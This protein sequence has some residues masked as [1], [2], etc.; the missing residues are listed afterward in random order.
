MNTE[1]KK[2]YFALSA[3]ALLLVSACSTDFVSPR[4][5]SSEPL[6]EYFNTEARIFESLVAAYDPLE[7]FDYAFGQYD[8]LHLVNDIM[9]D[10]MYCGG[11]NDGDQPILVKTHYYSLTPTEQPNQI[12]TVCYS[13]INRANTLLQ[14]VDG[15]AALSDANKV[16]YRAEATVL[17]NLYYTLL[18]KYWGNIP[19]YEENLKAPYIGTQ[20]GHDEVYANI[21]KSLE[22]VIALNVLPMKAAVGNEGRVTQAMAYMLYAEVVM[23]QKDNSRYQT[24]LNYMKEIITSSKYSLVSDFASIWLE[25]GEWGSESIWEINYISEGG[26]RSWGNSIA[27]GGEVYSV[28][29]GIPAEKGTEFQEGWGFGTIAKSAYDMYDNTDI[30]RD[31]GILNFEAYATAH[32]GATYTPRWQDTGYFNL[33]YLPYKGGNHGYLA[34]DNLNYGNNF[35]YYR[36][37]ETL[38]NAAE[39]SNLLGQDGTS[40]LTEVRNRAKSQDTGTSYDDIIQER[41]KEFVGEGKRYWDL[42][43]SGLA[44]QVLKGANHEYRTNDW[45]ETKKYWPIPQ[46]EIDKDPALKQ[47]DYK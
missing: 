2:I 33:K 30:R 46:S 12:W 7:W 27:V 22:S 47:N 3:A 31:G 43:R 8:A 34:D 17:R 28:L 1:M 5:N 16:L 10:D 36:Y 42:V 32:A 35:R 9:A 19:Y 37:A 15:V 39:L 21:V 40:Y 18:W 13:G 23:Y 44:S 45:N 6:N 26:V 11:S 41:H 14:Y 4:H 29:C 20:L 38:L 25:S 24:A